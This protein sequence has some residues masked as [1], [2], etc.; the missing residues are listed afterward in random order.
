MALEKSSWQPIIGW[1][2]ALDRDGKPTGDCHL[3]VEHPGPR[4]GFKLPRPV[5]GTRVRFSSQ[6]SNLPPDFASNTC[7]NCAAH[8]KRRGWPS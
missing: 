3:L 5:C 2:P 6:T 1:A 8:A 7:G 4:P